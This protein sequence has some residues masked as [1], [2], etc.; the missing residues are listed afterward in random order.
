MPSSRTPPL[1]SA[2]AKPADAKPSKRGPQPSNRGQPRAKQLPSKKPA[3][4][5]KAGTELVAQKIFLSYKQND[6]SDGI[7][8]R[9]YY[10]LQPHDVWLDKMQDENR[11]TSGMMAGVNECA[12][13]VAVLSGQYFSSSFCL[14]ELRRAM[15]REKPIVA[16]FNCAKFKVSEALAWIPNEFDVL[17]S[18]ELIKLD[19]DDEYFRV[20]I[21]KIVKRIETV[22]PAAAKELELD[23]L[24]KLFS[25]G[26][27]PSARGT[28]PAQ[29]EANWHAKGEPT[30]A[31]TAPAAN[32]LV[33]STMSEKTTLASIP[34]EVPTLPDSAIG[35]PDI[36]SALKACVLQSTAS[37]HT[38]A[39]TATAKVSQEHREAGGIGGFFSGRQSSAVTAT[40]MGG[41]GKTMTAAALVRDPEVR[42][43]F[44]KIC[45]V[46]IGQE[47][48]TLTLQQTLYRQLVRRVLPES[49]R[50]DTLLALEE[51]KEAVKDVAVL[52]VLDDVWLAAHVTPLN[53][54]DGSNGRSAVVVTTRVRSLLDGA[55]E[56]QCSTLSAEASLELLLRAGGCEHLLTKPPGAALEAVEL[57]G[58]LPLGERFSALALTTSLIA[59]PQS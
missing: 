23:E 35:R 15:E 17:K 14:Q 31:A 58:R 45:W 8:M 39:I 10:E 53:F 19:E 5:T 24:R 4:N 59:P 50:T 20:G 27:T 51:L 49:A 22:S 37:A 13:F 57:C 54:V 48:D 11:D 7:V 1:A 21:A 43:A 36:I 30:A 38:T 40:G 28:S 6:G 34:P 18:K 32:Q 16:C 41:V 33:A 52:L 56:V 12:L 25:S 26:P 42:S 29:A 46:S 2:A 3:A 55:A 9:L 44:D 47:S